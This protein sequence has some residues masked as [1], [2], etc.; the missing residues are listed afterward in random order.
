MTIDSL[1][2]KKTMKKKGWSN[3]YAPVDF[4]FFYIGKT[5][6]SYNNFLCAI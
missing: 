3:I 2:Y 5:K 4:S 1:F 6:Q